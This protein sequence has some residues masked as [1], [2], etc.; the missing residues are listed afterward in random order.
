MQTSKTKTLYELKVSWKGEKKLF[1]KFKIN[2]SRKIII[3][4]KEEE[5]RVDK[6]LSSLSDSEHPCKRS[7]KD[8][9]LEKRHS[10]TCKKGNTVF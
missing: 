5:K 3:K 4:K 7:N 8:G 6:F 2:P 1:S 9:D 10:F